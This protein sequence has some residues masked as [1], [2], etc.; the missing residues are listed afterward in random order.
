ML[1]RRKVFTPLEK[2][3]RRLL[4]ATF[5]FLILSFFV[6][7]AYFSDVV[8]NYSQNRARLHLSMLIHEAI[9]Q[10]VVPNIQVETLIRQKMNAEGYVTE[11]FIDVM[12]INRLMSRLTLIVQERL[13]ASQSHTLAMP[14]GAMFGHPWFTSYGPKIPIKVEMMG[15]LKSDI[16]TRT[17]RYGINNTLMEVVIK[18]EA[19]A[20]VILP[21][22]RDE[23][24]LETEIPLVIQLIHG[25]V[26][27]FYYNSRS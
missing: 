18:T 7:R 25:Q 5:L 19:R 26:P 12:Q 3:K 22:Q 14:L 2:L 9:S 24:I 27:R 4:L 23:V 20:L 8:K 21:F 17:R 15:N 6:T 10:E 11:V 13:S 16:V 1:R